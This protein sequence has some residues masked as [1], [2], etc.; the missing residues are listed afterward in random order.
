MAASTILDFENFHILAV[1]RVKSVQM[2][3]GTQFCDDWLNR[4]WH[5]DFSIFFSKCT[6]SPSWIFKIWNFNGQED[7]TASPSQISFRSVKPLLRCSN[8]SIFPRRW[9]AAILDL[10]RVFGPPTKGI[11]WS[12]SVI[13]V[14]NLVGIDTV[15]S[16]ICKFSYFVT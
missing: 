14:Q 15:M 12:S 6:P 9:T 4:C 16:I 11:L 13:T 5:G 7:Q 3:Q 1:R 2:R 10:W 8:F